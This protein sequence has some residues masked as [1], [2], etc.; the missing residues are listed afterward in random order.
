MAF[1]RRPRP[2]SLSVLSPAEKVSG[3]VT[4]ASSRARTGRAARKRLDRA[5][6]PRER[7]ER[8]FIESSCEGRILRGFGYPRP[9]EVKGLR[10]LR[11]ARS[12]PLTSGSRGNIRDDRRLHR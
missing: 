3:K 7:E 6:A 11:G 12:A 10:P 5:K 1:F 8:R 4:P 2:F 9:S